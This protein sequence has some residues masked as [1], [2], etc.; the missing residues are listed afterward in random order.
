MLEGIEFAKQS[1]FRL[2][3][4]RRLLHGSPERVSLRWQA[5]VRDKLDELK[6]QQ[7]RIAAMRIFL[8]RAAKCRCL[9]IAECGRLLLKAKSK[10]MT[11][12]ALLF[13]LIAAPVWTQPE[14]VR[15][16]AGGMG[17]DLAG[18]DPGPIARQLF[19][20]APASAGVI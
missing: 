12:I 16:N 11:V 7:E 15:S 8:E 5:L 13:V 1:G 14:A 2:E 4:I 17:I 19:Y 6:V 18:L 10:G 20:V 9:D 3:E